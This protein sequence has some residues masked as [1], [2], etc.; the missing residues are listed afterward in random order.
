MTRPEQSGAPGRPAAGLPTRR[1]DAARLMLQP[2]HLRA[3]LALTPQPSLRNASLAGLQAAV[4]AAIALPLVLLSPWAP[5][6]GFA[7]LGTLAALF[8]RFAAQ[9]RRSRVVFL[10]GLSL[11]SAVFTMSAAAWLGASDSLLMLLLALSCGGF[12]LLTVSVDFGPPG[13]LIFVFAAGAAMAPAETFH[14]V[15]QRSGATAAVAALAWLICTATEVFRHHATEERRFPSIPM[16]PLGHRLIAAG[17]IAL[18]AAAAVFASHALGLMHPAWAAMG[19]LA[20][21]QGTHLHIN[22]SRAL[23]RMSGT[24]LGALLAWLVL[25]QEPSAQAVILVLIVLQVSTELIIGL[26]YGLGVILVTPM[27]LLM[28]HLAAPGAAGA[29]MAPERVANTLL[30]AAIGIAVAV[31]FSTLD[32]RHH[33]AHH[34]ATRKRG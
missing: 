8:G 32:D 16:R 4:T 2:H 9:G 34:H 22:M 18:G 10:S 26:N 5:L 33:L 21:M 14:E 19:A 6:I 12:F 30:G 13:A 27:A 3:S 25:I 11:V 28:S 1:I 29:D 31:L 7:S 17:R 15:A 24:I 20:V 23:Q